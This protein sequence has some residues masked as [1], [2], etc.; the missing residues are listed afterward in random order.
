[1]VRMKAQRPGLSVLAA[2]REKDGVSSL[3]FRGEEEE[4]GGGR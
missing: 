4:G 2:K 1:M 3:V